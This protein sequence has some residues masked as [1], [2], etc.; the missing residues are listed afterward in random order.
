MIKNKYNYIALLISVFKK[1]SCEDSFEYLESIQNEKPCDYSTKNMILL[2]K[3]ITFDE[4]AQ[5]YGISVSAVYK[6][7]KRY[8][9]KHEKD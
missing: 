8:K 3:T 7:I 4:I 5:L 9:D 2:K 1:K 6:R